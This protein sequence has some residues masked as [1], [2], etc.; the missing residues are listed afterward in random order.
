MQIDQ[1]AALVTGGAS[2]LG[3]ATAQRLGGRRRRVVIVD[4]PSSPGAEVA[5]GLG[6]DAVF[7]GRRCDGR[8]RGRGRAGRGRA[9][10]EAAAGGGELRRHRP[11]RAAH[12]QAGPHDLAMFRQV[13]QVNLIGT[14]NV[15]RL[16]AERMLA[17][18]RWT[19]ASA[20]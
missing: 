9:D 20:A 13:I 5:A 6:A 17:R 7:V 4:L 10:G 14:F 18:S 1:S 8:R 19:T 15:I 16:A 2:G 11:R 3:K 12:R